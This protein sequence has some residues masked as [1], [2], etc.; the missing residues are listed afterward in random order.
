MTITKFKAIN[1]WFDIGFLN[2]III[3]KVCDI[4]FIVKMIEELP[5]GGKFCI[6]VYDS[7]MRTK[8]GQWLV[9]FLNDNCD[10]QHDHITDS[11]F[12]GHLIDASILYGTKGR[13]HPKNK[14]QLTIPTKS[15]FSE[16]DCFI[17]IIF[18]IS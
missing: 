14:S 5:D 9:D 18:F 7:W 8:Y 17:T 11:P 13:G 2:T 3:L 1:L 12:D 4:Y 10:V 6:L 16:N 15:V